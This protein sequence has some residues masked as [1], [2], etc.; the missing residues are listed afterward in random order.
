MKELITPSNRIRTLADC[1][2]FYASCEIA[3]RPNL[4]DRPVCVCRDRDIV[5]AANYIAKALGVGTGTASRDAK[6]ILGNKGVF[7]EPDMDYY[8]HMS[9]RVRECISDFA[10]D[11]EVF[12]I[13]EAF[14]DITKNN[15]ITEHAYYNF[16][17]KMQDTVYQNVGVPVSFG[18]AKTK[19]QAKMLSKINKPFGV[20]VA[21]SQDSFIELVGK[22][23]ITEI[24]FIA[25]RSARKLFLVESVKDFMNLDESKVKH[26]LHSPWLKVYF[27]M[28]GIS[29]WSPNKNEKPKGIGRSKS[30]HPHFTK[31]RDILW[32]HLISNFDKA[33]NELVEV[34][35]ACR[36]VGVSLRDK[37]FRRYN[38]YFTFPWFTMN[39]SVIMEQLKPLFDSVFIPWIEYRT[40]GVM[41]QQLNYSLQRYWLFDYVEEKRDDLFKKVKEINSKFWKE[42]ITTASNI[43]TNTNTEL[44][45]F[46]FAY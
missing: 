30:F 18:V 25:E 21:L 45:V 8:S 22:K 39:K 9:D 42:I 37:D 46:D 36:I 43:K 15:N 26:I 33:Y 3:R 35:G 2:S 38:N 7:I 19:L 34:N 11:V 14:Y 20:A 12:S 28:H 31:N 1:D 27:E 6:K 5:L 17:K 13:D 4:I 44:D 29:A 10:N 32:G 40:T 41:F 24:P 16:A 23:A